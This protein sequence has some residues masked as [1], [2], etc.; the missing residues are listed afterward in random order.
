MPVNNETKS[1]ICD[2]KKANTVKATKKHDELQYLEM[3]RH[4]MDNGIVKSDRTGENI[5][6]QGYFLK[7]ILLY[8]IRQSYLF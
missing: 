2:V 8:L 1:T 4:I 3:I 7:Y 6:S 5:K